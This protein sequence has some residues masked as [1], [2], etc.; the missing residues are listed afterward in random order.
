MKPLIGG[1]LVID[2]MKGVNN[3]RLSGASERRIRSIFESH[4]MAKGADER[5]RE[6]MEQCLGSLRVASMKAEDEIHL[7]CWAFLE[8]MG[9]IVECPNR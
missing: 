8:E 5:R 4:G 6:L 1:R 7:A 2:E 9:Q 3:V